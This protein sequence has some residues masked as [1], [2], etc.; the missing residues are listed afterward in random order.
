MAMQDYF[1]ECKKLETKT[2]SDG[3]GGFE[4]VE[5]LGIAF[6]GLA[7]RK[8][9]SEQ[10]IGALRGNENTQYNFHCVAEIPL[11]KDDKIAFTQNGETVYIRLTSSAV[12]NT[13]R[14][15]QTDWKTYDAERYTPTTIVTE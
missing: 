8:G 4:T 11:D 13:E 1:Y 3:L 12:I 14:S 5:Y 9:A 10:L 6:K 15:T 7:V 2:V